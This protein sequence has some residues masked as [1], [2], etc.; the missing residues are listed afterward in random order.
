MIYP[1]IPKPLVVKLPSIIRV[2]EK[3]WQSLKHIDT[4]FLVHSS[5]FV[6][7]NQLA[8]AVVVV[9][10]GET[11]VSCFKY[12]AADSSCNTT[13]VGTLNANR[14]SSKEWS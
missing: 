11:V 5:Y 4:V 12:F 9:A 13:I 8:K 6:G 2:L 3:F 14:D 7:S 1:I 10:D